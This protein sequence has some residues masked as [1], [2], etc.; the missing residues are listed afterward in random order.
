MNKWCDIVIPVDE[1]ILNKLHPRFTAQI[2]Y[3]N[4][5]S[6]NLLT[7]SVIIFLQIIASITYYSLGVAFLSAKIVQRN[8]QNLEINCSNEFKKR[9]NC[10]C[11]SNCKCSS[12]SIRYWRV[13]LRADYSF[14]NT[15][16]FDKKWSLRFSKSTFY[17][18][19]ELHGNIETRPETRH[20]SFVWV[21]RSSEW[22]AGAAIWIRAE[23]LNV[24]D[25][26]IDRGTE[27]K[28]VSYIRAARD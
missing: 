4:K 5:R 7:S 22:H 21:G 10:F 12:I 18:F 23:S 1:E 26:Q 14:S 15:L 9:Q 24:T 8:K 16:S 17:V 3:H 13:G 19:R 6:R 20:P 11:Q 2:I 25:R 28:G 27:Y